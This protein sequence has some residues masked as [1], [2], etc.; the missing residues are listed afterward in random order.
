MQNITSA[1]F[2]TVIAYLVP[3]L[4]AV[5][6]ASQ[7]STAL[8]GWLAATPPNAP[9]VGGFLYLTIVSLAAGM[10]VSALRWATIDRLHS[11]TGLAMPRLDFAKLAAN[12]EA[13]GLLIR[14]H[15]EHYQFYANMFVS[16]AFAYVCYR[17]RLGHEGPAWLETGF[18]VIELI[19]YVT[20][21]DTLR[22]YYS[23]SEQ[24]LGVLRN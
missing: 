18:I 15:Y 12:A 8:Q 1:N 14:I 17:I 6:G 19:F 10:T 2:G 23:R 24:L 5:L 13:F 20:S 7:F 9:T 4:T 11:K 22:K 3:G 21:R 16:T